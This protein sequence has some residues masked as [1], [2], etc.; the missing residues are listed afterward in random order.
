MDGMTLDE[1]RRQIADIQA[2]R[3]ALVAQANQQ[4]AFL[5]GKMAAYQEWL[6]R[7]TDSG[8]IAELEA[9]LAELDAAEQP[10][11]EAVEE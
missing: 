8:A 2:E 10:Q 6:E 5:N 11:A 9:Q 7:L 4:I 1:L 3:D